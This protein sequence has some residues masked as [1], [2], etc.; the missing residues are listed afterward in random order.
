MRHRRATRHFADTGLDDQTLTTLLDAARWAPSG[1]NL[2][3]I[4]FIVVREA[5][6]KGQLGWA[7]IN[8]RQVTEAPATVVFAGD[9]RVMHNNLETVIEQ[10]R[11]AG[12]IDERY[13]GFL[14]KFVPLA[15]K[16][17]PLGLNWLWKATLPP[18]LRRFTA[19][20]SLPAVH[21]RYW[22]AKQ[23]GLAA[24]NFMLAAHASGL[25]TCPIEG[26]DEKRLQKVLDM[27]R[28]VLPIIV[29]PVGHAADE[30]GS[31]TRLPADQQVHWERW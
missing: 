1:Y 8:Q 13:E 20:P 27:P 3:P 26:F 10:E 4:H 16:T 15:F 18:V 11:A 5:E 24:M 7:C 17:G 25:A 2:Q 23:A 9:K 12:A 28:S 6:Q 21:R 29:V 22:L 19:M 14:R 31:K 30:P